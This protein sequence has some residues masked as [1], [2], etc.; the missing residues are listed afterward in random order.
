MTDRRPETPRAQF[1]AW[2]ERVGL[3]GR[4]VAGLPPVV[5]LFS[6]EAQPAFGVAVLAAL[7]G[8]LRSLLKMREF[9]TA[10]EDA[11]RDLGFRLDLGVG[12]APG[13]DVLGERV[14]LLR[15]T[16]SPAQ[17][18]QLGVLFEDYMRTTDPEWLDLARRAV[19]AVVKDAVDEG[20]R[21][22]IVARL[23]LLS[24]PHLRELQRLRDRPE[25]VRSR[26]TV[27]SREA[28]PLLSVLVHVGFIREA[29]VAEPAEASPTV[30]TV[31]V[32]DTKAGDTKA[33]DTEL[34][35]T[36]LGLAALR[37]LGPIEP[38]SGR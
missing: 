15:G 26:L 9:E 14:E 28:N 32:G 6:L 35:P 16:L 3:P 2:P 1:T 20:S 21:R 18:D 27:R 4:I 25:R 36:A 5:A 19:R 29:P 17:V 11:L 38:G 33:G 23:P 7:S 34:R 22:T 30:A 8:S 10:V 13:G 12:E 31:R 24:V 37:L